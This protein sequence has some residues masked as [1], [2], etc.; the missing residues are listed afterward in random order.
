MTGTKD[1]QAIT[2]VRED[3]TTIVV[4]GELDHATSPQLQEA[5]DQALADRPHRIEVDFDQVT[6]C[7]FSGLNV[8]L[9]ARATFL[10]SRASTCVET[11]FTVVR[12][13]AP[14]T[15]LFQLTEAGPLFGIE[16]PPSRSRSSTSS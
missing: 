9:G 16:R 2:L 3:R 5:A 4:S 1:F 7:D 8:L 6:F 13:H 11:P 10:G 12:A 14:V 15:R